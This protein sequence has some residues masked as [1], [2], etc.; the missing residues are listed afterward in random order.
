M[1]RELKPLKV[2]VV[3]VSGIE[4]PEATFSQD[5]TDS[6]AFTACRLLQ[7]MVYFLIGKTVSAWTRRDPRY[8]N[9]PV[10]S[11]EEAR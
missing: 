5:R 3:Q 7:G 1:A 10:A 2:P 11:R 6:F 8:T 9:N 4:I